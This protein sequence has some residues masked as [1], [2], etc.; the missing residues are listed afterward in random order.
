[1]C[2]LVCENAK[3]RFSYNILHDAVSFTLLQNSLDLDTDIYSE[4]C[5]FQSAVKFIAGSSHVLLL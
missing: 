2:K 4:S 3:D 1:M 5:V